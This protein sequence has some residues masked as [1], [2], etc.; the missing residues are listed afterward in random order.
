MTI[1]PQIA[2]SS[3][4]PMDLRLSIRDLK[5]E[6]MDERCVKASRDEALESDRF[7]AHSRAVDRAMELV[8]NFL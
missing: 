2:H 6:G 5:V 1:V 8:K 3:Y 7:F 4:N